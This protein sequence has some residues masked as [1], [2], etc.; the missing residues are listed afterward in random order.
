MTNSEATMT[1]SAKS[2]TQQWLSFQSLVTVPRAV[3]GLGAIVVGVL[4]R[5]PAIV[6]G[7][8][9]CALAAAVLLFWEA[10]RNVIDSSSSG[11]ETETDDD[12]IPAEQKARKRSAMQAL[13]DI[14][15]ERSIGRLSEEDHETLEK[16]YRDEARAAMRAI[17]D[18]FGEWLQRA[19][20]E[21]K[22]L[23]QGEIQT[24][25]PEVV[26]SV[27]R[28]PEARMCAKC[29]TTNDHDAVFC[30]KCATRLSPEESA[31]AS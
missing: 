12:G 24:V 11:D 8:A 16:K 2:H 17:D 31:N 25:V 3:V 29:E 13:R 27:I 14:D 30:K 26:A 15:F 28:A 1:E 4:G 9:F 18:G 23:E 19:D 5:T 21:L 6:L 10:L 22:R 7:M 20:S